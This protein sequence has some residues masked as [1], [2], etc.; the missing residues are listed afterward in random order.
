MNVIHN[1]V[2]AV[3]SEF[4]SNG[5]SPI[6][7]DTPTIDFEDW[8]EIDVFSSFA[9]LEE[10][11]PNANS[12]SVSFPP[13]SSGVAL[14]RNSNAP[15]NNDDP[16]TN[17][18][19]SANQQSLKRGYPQRS[20]GKQ[21]TNPSGENVAELSK[22][23]SSTKKRSD[24]VPISRRKKKPKGMP[25]RPL[26]AYNLYFQAERT[27]IIAIQQEGNGPRIGFEGLGKIIGKKWRDLGSADKKEYSKL[28]EKDSERY[29]KEM[30]AYH[31]RKAKRFEEEDKRAA[32]QT[33]VLSG[34]SSSTASTLASPF[35]MRFPKGQGSMQLVALGRGGI[36]N[37]ALFTH[38]PESMVSAI[39]SLPPRRTSISYHP[40]H[41]DQPP[42]LSRLGVQHNNILEAL[43][44]QSGGGA[45]PGSTPPTFFSQP[46][47]PGSTE[48]LSHTVAH[49]NDNCAMPPGM[50]II[51][52]D[53]NGF[54]RKYRVQYTCYSMTKE[55]ANKYIESLT[56][57]RNSNSTASSTQV[58]AST[59]PNREFSEWGCGVVR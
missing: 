56:A 50:E 39:S 30:D 14:G 59:G 28:A 13:P 43:N 24:C 44:S 23:V 37:S 40:I 26:S 7:N 17:K 21:T 29:R 9:G 25:K 33:P 27:N 20:S 18:T 51:L 53:R 49:R 42:A 16:T 46:A 52:A 22:I 45:L 19:I 47:M 1:N 32:S 48:G 54:D 15:T 58:D 4:R 55:N 34:I 3:G 12:N 8:G 31:E 57:V 41:L 10:D 11:A 36:G 2:A 6:N 35:N 38:P 5:T